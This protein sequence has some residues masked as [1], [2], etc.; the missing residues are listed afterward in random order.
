MG[1][2]FVHVDDVEPA[3]LSGAVRFVLEVNIVILDSGTHAVDGTDIPVRAGT[4]LASI[5]R[6]GA[7]R[8]QSRRA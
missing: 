7:D 1:F 6:G 8:S 4:F 2:S 5:R 3:G